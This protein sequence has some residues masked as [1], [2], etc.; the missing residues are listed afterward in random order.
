[1]S[2]PKSPVSGPTLPKGSDDGG[3]KKKKKMSGKKKAAIVIPIVII[4]SLVLIGL[5][6]MPYINKNVDDIA[7]VSQFVVYKDGS[8]TKFRFSMVDDNGYA[9][10]SDA[11]VVLNTPK[12]KYN[13]TID[14]DEFQQYKLQLTGQPLIA[15]AWQD[16]KDQGSG[17]VFLAVTLPNGKVFYAK[18]Y[19]F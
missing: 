7:G 5:L 9:A 18:D 2:D 11:R 19:L 1:M 10:A 14:A 17:D 4:G 16:S 12:W 15:Y 13:F 8:L 6:S 3:E